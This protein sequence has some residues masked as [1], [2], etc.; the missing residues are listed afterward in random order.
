MV[1]VA[2]GVSYPNHKCMY[3]NRTTFNEM[4][5]SAIL[6]FYVTQSVSF[7]EN[8]IHFFNSIAVI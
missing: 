2:F 4:V 5:G 1:I 6:Y 8:T 3:W 7:S